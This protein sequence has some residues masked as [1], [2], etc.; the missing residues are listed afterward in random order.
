M[1]SEILRVGVDLPY[2]A[3][4]IEVRDYAQAME[5]IGFD[6]IGFSSHLCST[7]DTEFPAPI[8]QFDDPWHES[9]T[10][11]AY[12]A[13]VTSTIEINTSMLLLPLYPPVLA[14]KQ[15]AEVDLLL[16]G[17]LRIGASISWNPRESEA[18]GVDPTTRGTRFEE[19]VVVMRRLWDETAVDFDGRFFKLNKTGITPRPG[20]RIPI[21]FGAGDQADSGY[22]TARGI[23]RAARLADGF[24]LMAPTGF[25]P[26][27]LDGVVAA[28]KS[29]VAEAGRDPQS[30]G[31]E[32]RL[33]AQATTPDDWPVIIARA[34]G[35][36]VSHLSM[37]NRIA[38]GTVDQQIDLCR[39]FAEETRPL[40]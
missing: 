28:L 13:G 12:L 34:K 25:Q 15:A 1:N 39:R 17:R 19:Q 37:A 22:P 4:P 31:I 8:F 10:L 38:G 5:Q 7:L 32:E 18:L 6:H 27:R 24:K 2:F 30:F 20:R 9:F 36:G 16:Q 29:A 40:W 23:E 21:W 35:R 3:S 33:V 14:A 26:D 11:A